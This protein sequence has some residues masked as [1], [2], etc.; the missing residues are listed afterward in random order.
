M[1]LDRQAA[2]GHD[3][4]APPRVGIVGG[5][6]GIGSLF[7]RIVARSGAA[8]LVSDRDTALS[9]AEVAAWSD[10]V[11][12]AVPLR[13]TPAVLT[14]IAPSV[15]PDAVLVSLGSLME[16]SVEPLSGRPGASLLLHPLFGPGRPSLE[17]AAL[18]WASPTGKVVA[19]PHWSWLRGL[20]SSRGASL[21]H[22][23]PEEHDR[24]MAAAQ[25]LMH[26]MA[27]T[28]APLLVEM[29][30]GPDALHW[31]SPTLRLHLALMG[32]ILHQDPALY[33][34]ILALNRHSIG[35][36]DLLTA[37]LTDLRARVA[38]GPDAVAALFSE[39][40]DALGEAGPRFAAEGDAALGE[41]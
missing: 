32:R 12:V 3:P 31:M 6:G 25:A 27:A 4:H 18:A 41:G 15:R 8:T 16:P 24:A 36:I 23:T 30:P 20:L 5:R 38:E 21:T 33:G 40:R 10:L 39:A 22:T 29:L 11:L 19:S 26:G 2:P 37:R 34:D 1:P 9:N 14:S 13:L 35:A 28:V 17:G 7:Q